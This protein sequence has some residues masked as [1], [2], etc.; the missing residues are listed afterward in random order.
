MNP[1]I[2]IHGREALPV[3]A[4]P[5]ITGWGC[6]QLTLDPFDLAHLLASGKFLAG[7][8]AT[9]PLPTHRLNGDATWTGMAAVTWDR[10]AKGMELT[11]EQYA[12]RLQSLRSEDPGT[13]EQWL[14]RG[15]G[16]LPAGVFVWRDDFERFWTVDFL[17]RIAMPPPPDEGY[18]GEY[19]EGDTS[20]ADARERTL[21]RLAHRRSRQMARAALFPSPPQLDYD[22]DLSPAC[23]ALVL[24]GFATAPLSRANDT[25]AATRARQDT[26]IKRRRALK[27]IIQALATK[28]EGTPAAFATDAIPYRKLDFLDHVLSNRALLCGDRDMLPHLDGIRARFVHASGNIPTF[29]NEDLSAL[30]IRFLGGSYSKTVNALKRVP[31]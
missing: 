15:I 28:A 7:F 26:I 6:Y 10:I 29:L 18:P 5:C 27:T 17:P 4:L 12:Q 2:P 31:L 30:G 11:M 1:I 3:R 9:Q 14:L 8:T 19:R 25:T 16:A 24:E 21:H 22:P 23:I 20:G 13:H